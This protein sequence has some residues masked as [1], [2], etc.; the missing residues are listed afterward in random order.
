MFHLRACLATYTPPLS[1]PSGLV[2]YNKPGINAPILAILNLV[3]IHRHTSE[4]SAQGLSRSFALAIEAAARNGL[5]LL[6]SECKLD[7]ANVDK[8]LDDMEDERTPWSD[9][10]PVL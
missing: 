4:Y 2:A 10:V 6:L 7:S 1:P 9:E 3:T 5:Q 8:D